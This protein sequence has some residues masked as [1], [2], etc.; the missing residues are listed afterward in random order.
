HG[1]LGEVRRVSSREKGDRSNLPERPE[2]GHRRA[3][4]VGA[5]IEPVPFSQPQPRKILEVGPGTGAV[6]RRI[7]GGMGADDQ[8]DLVELNGTFVR[9]L[10]R[11]FQ[12][13]PAFRGV[14]DRA[15]IHHCPIEELPGDES[16]DVIVSGL[17]LNNFS[18]ADVERILAVLT[19]RL[20]PEGMLSF[21]EYIAV[22]PARALLSG[23]V[24]RTR[25]RTI[26]RTMRSVL[27]H[28]EI[29]RDAVWLNVPPAWV[30]HLRK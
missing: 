20:A 23:R 27:K 18:A 3:A 5:Q 22:R 8:L 28:H 19:D 17:P 11:R 10:E 16:Y 1:S 26:G 6:T 13:E 24:E 29:R 9:Q 2:G 15:R 25:L 21:F 14:A 30:H 7:V 4:L 12:T